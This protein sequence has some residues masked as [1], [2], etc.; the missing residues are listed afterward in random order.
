MHHG[1][2]CPVIHRDISSKNILLD[3]EYQEA[4]ITDFGIAKFLN[5]DS[6]N[7]TSFVGTFGYAAPEIAFTI[8]ANEKCDVYSFGVLAWEILLGRHPSDLVC[9]LIEIPT[10]YKLP[11]K[12]V[13]DKRL[14]PPTNLVADEVISIAKLALACLNENPCSRPTMEHVSTKRMKRKP[15]LADQFDTITLGKLMMQVDLS[16]S[17]TTLDQMMTRGIMN[18]YEIEE[19]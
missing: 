4:H 18:T 1:L 16:H 6:N 13:V 10:S 17:I 8:Q 15:H 5:L 19:T 9:S 14:P 12:D 3:F 11:L 2:S 7:M